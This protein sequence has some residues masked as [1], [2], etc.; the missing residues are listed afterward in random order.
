ML[1]LM[2]NFAIWCK[3]STHWKRPWWWE[4]PKE[5]GEV[6]GRG[7]DGWIASLTQWTRIWAISGYSW[8]TGKTEL[9]QSMR[10]QRVRH[11]LATEQEQICH[12]WYPLYILWVHSVS[13]CPNQNELQEFFKRYT[14]YVSLDEDLEWV[15]PFLPFISS[16]IL[17]IVYLC[18]LSFV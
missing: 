2:L 5:K 4:R 13:I 3:Q 1:I 9:L 14:A 16:L 11:N 18:K 8:R 17:D 7:W 15:T 10:L 12:H 6:G